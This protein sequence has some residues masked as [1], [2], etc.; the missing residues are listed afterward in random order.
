M[1]SSIKKWGN[2]A[3]VRIPR[4]V[5]SEA[6]LE[7]GADV[8]IFSSKEGEITLRA[9][10]KRVNIQEL[11]DGYNEGCCESEELDWGEPMGDEE[12]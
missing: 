12:W 9:V 8:E 2:S 6:K 10:K 7:E 3:A 1:T 4:N 5:L 11:F